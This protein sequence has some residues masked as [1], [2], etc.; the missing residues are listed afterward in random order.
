MGLPKDTI[1]IN[2]AKGVNTKTDDKIAGPD[3]MSIVTD[4]RFTQD[5]RVVKRNGLTAQGTSFQGDPG[6]INPVA[7]AA[8]GLKTKAF[9][10][11]NQLCQVNNGNLFSQYEG[12]NKWVFKG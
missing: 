12:Q 6:F 10:H 5:K 11:E 4:G 7:I 8:S 3:Q 9:A 1:S 2:L